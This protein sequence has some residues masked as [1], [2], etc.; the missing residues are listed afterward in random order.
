M[1]QNLVPIALFPVLLLFW[2]CANAT[3]QDETTDIP[4][5]WS[6]SYSFKNHQIHVRGLGEISP[7]PV[8]LAQIEVITPRKSS[9][10]KEFGIFDFVIDST[11]TDM[12]NDRHFEVIII[13]Q[14]TGTGA[15]GN[16]V[17]HEW[18]GGKLIERKLPELTEEQRQGYM[19]H[20]RF[21]VEDKQ[22]VRSFPI[23]KPEDP[24]STPTGGMRTLSYRFAGKEWSVTME[25]ASSV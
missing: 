12:D 2:G 22:L 7:S 6:Q 11:V 16:A 10:M 9:I 1:N 4:Y 13:T 25:P 18:I 3:R 20:D 17:I 5:H 24:N 14:S 19:G 21:Q 8:A 15:Y 23:Y